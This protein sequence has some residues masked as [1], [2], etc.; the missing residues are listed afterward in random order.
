MKYTG[1][2]PTIINPLRNHWLWKVKKRGGKNWHT[3]IKWDMFGS[4]LL[5]CYIT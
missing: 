2:T 1:I 3:F 5:D 4:L